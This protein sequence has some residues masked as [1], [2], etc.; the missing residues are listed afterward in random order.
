[1]TTGPRLSRVGAF[2]AAALLVLWIASAAHAATTFTVNTLQDTVGG[3]CSGGGTC[4]IRDAINAA[5]ADP[6]DNVI[7]LPTGRID[8]SIAPDGTDD[9]NTGDLNVDN[10]G[11]LTI[12]GP[13]GDPKDSTISANGLDRVLNIAGGS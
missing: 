9:N 10:A 7:A 11:A 6:G 12:Q 13:T 4:S 1:M 2:A 5:N 8:L 3:D